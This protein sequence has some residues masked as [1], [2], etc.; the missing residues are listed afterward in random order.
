MFGWLGLCCFH[1]QFLANM[2]AFSGFFSSDLFAFSVACFPTKN[3]HFGVFWGYHCLRKH[4][5]VEVMIKWLNILGSTIRTE[6]YMGKSG[7]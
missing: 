3:D 2:I 4:P 5:N 7:P 1:P 6:S